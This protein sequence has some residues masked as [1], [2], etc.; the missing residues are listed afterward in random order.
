MSTVAGLAAAARN[1]VLVKGGLALEMPARL[2]A[3]AMDKT[4]TLTDGRPSVATVVAL[5]GHTV[6]E[7][8]ERAGA[9]ESSSQA[10]S[11]TCDLRLR[12]CVACNPDRLPTSP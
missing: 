2:K 4:G 11:G 12:E 10:S 6:Q 9:T 8:I 5:N 3:T 7:L 1:R